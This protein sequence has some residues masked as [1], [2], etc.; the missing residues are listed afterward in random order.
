MRIIS[1]LLVFLMLLFSCVVVA[2][3]Q[4]MYAEDNQLNGWETFGETR[5]SEPTT[6]AVLNMTTEDFG[7]A[8]V[9][10]GYGVAI[11]GALGIGY[12]VAKN[13][14]KSK[15]MYL[16][17]IQLIA[18]S[19]C[20]KEPVPVP[21]MVQISFTPGDV[22][23]TS[24][25]PLGHVEFTSNDVLYL[26]ASGT[27]EVSGRYLGTLT[28]GNNVGA[29]VQFTG[30][31][32]RWYDGEVLSFYYFGK[33]KISNDGSITINFSDQTYYDKP[34]TLENDLDNIANHYH[35]GL[36]RIMATDDCV[37]T[38]FNGKLRNMIALGVFDTHEFVE[39]SN[40][41]IIS[42]S[43]LNNMI[44][45]NVDGSIE[46]GVAGIYPSS[47]VDN[48]SGHIVIGRGT[49]K[50]YVALLPQSETES[51]NISVSFVSN[52]KISNSNLN[53]I[54]SVNSFLHNGVDGQSVIGMPVSASNYTSNLYIDFPSPEECMSNPHVFTLY[55][56]NGDTKKVV[57][58]QG[59]LVYDKGR[60]KQ[61]KYPWNICE[62][63]SN[64]DIYV[65]GV[66]D[67]FGWAASGYDFGQ[68]IFQPYSNATTQYPAS[69]GCGYGIPASNYKQSFFPHETYRRSDW[70]WYQF[71]MHCFDEYTISPGN[72][73]YWRTPGQ[74]E[75]SYLFN[76]RAT[77][78]TNLIDYHTGNEVTN[79]RFV[80][81]RINGV[82]GVL[83][84]PDTYNHPS[85]I[86]LSYINVG[87]KEGLSAN[88]LTGE[89]FEIL[90]AEGV[91]FMPMDGFY[92]K[93][94]ESKIYESGYYWSC[95]TQQ[96]DMAIYCKITENG[97]NSTN[98]I[99]RYQG[100]FVRLVFQVDGSIF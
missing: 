89:Q 15:M 34:S 52:N 91:E 32:H 78:S 92:K 57:F 33:N 11:L 96:S 25:T 44:K 7:N 36:C 68:A 90:H 31:V 72:N 61:H 97:I 27:N 5:S 17:I 9:P 82:R 60:F 62:I 58:S 84:F 24:I 38:I 46:Y 6:G 87:T 1:K 23:R 83:V 29:S 95:K 80:K 71:G 40:V 10:I 56:E 77:N 2:N 63:N 13:K 85:T 79:A 39:N 37:T 18:L 99:E 12:C 70:G 53:L 50:K 42:N 69:V 54:I 100:L 20:S 16:L 21:E 14:K 45:V 22:Q 66:F 26:Y 8:Y 59:N 86:Q 35:I 65:N 55:S 88:Q 73:S 47:A 30:T 28:N 75:W 81:A 41:K 93:A 49:D 43:G 64:S 19:G 4:V 74:A 3:S 51:A 76:N 94:I 48:Q 98:N 67:V